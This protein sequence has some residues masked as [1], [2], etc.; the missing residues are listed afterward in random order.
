MCA[1]VCVQ[2]KGNDLGALAGLM[3][4]RTDSWGLTLS[5]SVPRV[6]VN[7]GE[8]K[9]QFL[10]YV[11]CSPSYCGERD[12]LNTKMKIIFLTEFWLVFL[13]QQLSWGHH[14]AITVHGWDRVT[15]SVTAVERGPVSGDSSIVNQQGWR[16]LTTPLASYFWRS[17][18]LFLC[19]IYIVHSI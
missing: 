10:G 4:C 11:I 8:E 12:R 5:C 3:W 7:Q 18:S 6:G 14:W 13:R 16:H 15:Y 2:D 19:I 1:S 17:L 9:F